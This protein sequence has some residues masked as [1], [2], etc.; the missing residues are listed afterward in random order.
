MSEGSSEQN[1]SHRKDSK[2]ANTTRE[3]YEQ[4]ISA[5][6]ERARMTSELGGT[7]KPKIGRAEHILVTTEKTTERFEHLIDEEKLLIQWILN[8][9][10][11]NEVKEASK[12]ADIQR[13][14]HMEHGSV[15]TITANPEDPDTD[16]GYSTIF[17]TRKGNNGMGDVALKLTT[18]G[19]C[20]LR[21]INKGLP[22]YKSGERQFL[23]TTHEEAAI[24]EHTLVETRSE[25]MTSFTTGKRK[26]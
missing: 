10:G 22:T 12:Y 25:V 20:E 14:I 19:R 6:T 5:I 3:S 8:D 21:V 23:W 13:R 2:S 24:I 18:D 16:R 9:P 7:A 1:R 11:P 15:R 17:I 26:F 4:A